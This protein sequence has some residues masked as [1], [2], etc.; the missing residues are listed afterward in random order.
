MKGKA[1][2]AV[3]CSPFNP[4]QQLRERAVCSTKYLLVGYHPLS[5][6]PERFTHEII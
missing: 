4:S 2:Y 1:G 6:S 3:T 5:S